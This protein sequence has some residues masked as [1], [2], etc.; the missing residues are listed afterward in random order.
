MQRCRGRRFERFFDTGLPCSLHMIRSF[1]VCGHML[2]Y[3]TVDL[4][5]GYAFYSWLGHPRLRQQIHRVHTFTWSDGW[6][7]CLVPA[8][9]L[10]SSSPCFCRGKKRRGIRNNSKRYVYLKK[11]ALSNV[12][13]Q[14]G[15]IPTGSIC[16]WPPEHEHVLIHWQHGALRT[17]QWFYMDLHSC[18]E[19]KR[20]ICWSGAVHD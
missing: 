19:T 9:P 1:A 10:L 13:H 7:C 12:Q 5:S 16:L 11:T 3:E 20:K 17:L 15:A 6:C 8:S 4:A 14:M 2:R 18:Q